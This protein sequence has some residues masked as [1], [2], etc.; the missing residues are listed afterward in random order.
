MPACAR[1]VGWRSED[2]SSQGGKRLAATKGRRVPTQDHTTSIRDNDLAEEGYER[3]GRMWD[4]S[5]RKRTKTARTARDPCFVMRV[6]ASP[7]KPEAPASAG[8]SN[9][10]QRTTG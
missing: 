5:S 7:G 8:A 4:H 3:S 9:H 1:V 10:G 2:R 6:S